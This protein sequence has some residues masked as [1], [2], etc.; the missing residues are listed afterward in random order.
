MV[1]ALL[2]LSVY[3][4]PRRFEKWGFQGVKSENSGWRLDVRKAPRVPYPRRPLVCPVRV[5]FDYANPVVQFQVVIVGAGCT[6]SL[7]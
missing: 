3:E 2:S 7:R 1:S 6:V 5:G 4:A